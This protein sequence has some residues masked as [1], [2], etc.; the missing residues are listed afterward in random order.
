MSSS[1][2][3]SA[4]SSR[5]KVACPRCGTMVEWDPQNRYRPFCSERCKMIDLGAWANESY[6][7]PVA[8]DDESLDQDSQGEPPRN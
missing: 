5:K 7:I 1:S 3:R 8:E 6:R 4:T 2:S